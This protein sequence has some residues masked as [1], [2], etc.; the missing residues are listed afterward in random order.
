MVQVQV[1]GE[2]AARQLLVDDSL[3]ELE[4]GVQVDA[5]V[6]PSELGYAQI[7]LLHPTDFTR[8]V[9]EG[10][11]LGKVVEAEVVCPS[12]PQIVVPKKVADSVMRVATRS[13]TEDQVAIIQDRIDCL[14]EL[15]TNLTASNGVVI[16]DKM[17]IIGDHPAQQFERGTQQGGKFKC[18]GCGVRDTLEI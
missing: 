15:S 9:R 6:K 1:N 3:M 2:S 11:M 14:H 4:T 8:V 17:F 16:H 7:S 18:G 12:E 5:I 13:S 10:C